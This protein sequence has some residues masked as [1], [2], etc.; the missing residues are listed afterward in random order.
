[1]SLCLK[2]LV[3]GHAEALSA[4]V[5]ALG[6]A[7]CTEDEPG[8]RFEG[9]AELWIATL[10]DGTE[11]TRYVLASP[12][13][14]LGLE[15][16]TPPEDLI[17]GER[18]VVMGERIVGTGEREE[19][20][21]I[22]VD[23]Y[24]VLERARDG[25]ADMQ[26]AL[27]GNRTRTRLKV[28][29][30]MYHW[31]NQDSLTN[32]SM[33]EKIFT[34]QASLRQWYRESSYGLVDIEGDV[35]GWYKVDKPSSG[36]GQDAAANARS[37]ARAKGVNLDAYDLW[38]HYFPRSSCGWSGLATVGRPFRPAR[39]SYYN[40][41]SGCVTLAQ[42]TMHNLGGAHSRSYD[43]GNSAFS[44][45]GCTEKTYGDPFDPMGHGC[46]QTSA[47]SK[48]TQAWFGKCNSVAVTANGSFD[49]VPIE[50]PSD[51]IQMLQVRVKDSLCPT[52]IGSPCYYYVAY[53][54]R[55]GNVDGNQP[56]TAQIFKGLQFHVGSAVDFEG[57]SAI[58]GPTLL[59]M[60]PTSSRGFDDP[61]LEMGKTFT[62]PAGLKVTLVSSSAASARVKLEFPG[63]G[64]G[65]PRCIDG[66]NPTG[67]DGGR[68]AGDGG[69]AAD[70]GVPGK[71]GG[72][73]PTDAGDV[74]QADAGGSPQADAGDVPQ[75][76]AGAPGT[77]GSGVSSDAGDAPQAA[78][79]GCSCRVSSTKERP[80]TL[81]AIL[82][83]ALFAFVMVRPSKPR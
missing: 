29:V 57:G 1:M 28:A 51:G 76:D 59:D 73:R 77:D 33:H 53:R 18:I 63:G 19:N 45:S 47:F 25:V 83:L 44:G 64:S 55:L 38:L 82:F 80:S 24:Q 40:G 39:N 69:P 31:G 70:A 79:G 68:D 65:A 58:K 37:A 48:A 32:A 46:W 78:E 41:A 12:L 62:D 11:R 10:D 23:S 4:V 16:A 61:A 26:S 14:E 81:P 5:L 36:C 67:G 49:L 35:F 15:F 22:R 54:Q 7:G 8:T 50:N 60:T 6:F 30:L 56:E 72:S 27:T 52:R 66:S 13:G 21:S 17:G 2:R 74:P 43:C 42:E 3:R 75:A 71:D 20:D 34:S 9:Q